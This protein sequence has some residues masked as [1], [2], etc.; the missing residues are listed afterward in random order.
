VFDDKQVT[1]YNLFAPG[2]S[3]G[4]NAS[5]QPVAV[6]CKVAVLKHHAV[7]YLTLSQTE[8]K[9][10]TVASRTTAPAD[11]RLE[12]GEQTV[13]SRSRAPDETQLSL[14]LQMDLAESTHP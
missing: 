3:P 9:D 14:P 5:M 11:E 4:C 2:F 6:F 13:Y 12:L 7:R 8:L 1:V 10:Q